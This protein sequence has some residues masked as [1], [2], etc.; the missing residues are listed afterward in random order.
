[1]DTFLGSQAVLVEH[2]RFGF[3]NTKFG[4]FGQKA[5]ELVFLG[6]GILNAEKATFQGLGGNGNDELFGRKQQ[7]VS[8]KVIGL[9]QAGTGNFVGETNALQRV[10]GQ[11]QVFDVIDPQDALA[12]WTHTVVTDDI[13]GINGRI[14]V[15]PMQGI[16]RRR[17]RSD[18]RSMRGWNRRTAT[19]TAA[20]TTTVESMLRSCSGGGGTKVVGS[21][22]PDTARGGN[23][24]GRRTRR[25]AT[26]TA[27]T[28]RVVVWVAPF[29]GD[30]VPFVIVVVAV[31]TG[32]FVDTEGRLSTKFNQDAWWRV[33]TGHGVLEEVVVLKD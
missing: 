27:T 10:G 31:M 22:A 28:A 15:R 6:I 20:A 19:A 32:S 25:T 29:G 16:L 18:G 1:M 33:R 30:Q 26:G 11:N 14:A 23:P 13:V 5:I 21:N 9:T 24:Y 17:Y 4:K 3:G 7:G 2:V 8:G 12:G